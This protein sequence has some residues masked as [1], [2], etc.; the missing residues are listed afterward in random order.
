MLRG[1]E[2]G[3]FVINDP[4]STEN[5]ER[6]GVMMNLRDKLKTCGPAGCHR[7]KMGGLRTSFY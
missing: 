6:Y 4:N 3:K 7:S 2:E 5:S 1:V